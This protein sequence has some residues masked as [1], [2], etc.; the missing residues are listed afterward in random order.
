MQDL[1]TDGST[2]AGRHARD[3]D[4]IVGDNGNIIRIVGTARDDRIDNVPSSL[5]VTFNYDN[6]GPQKTGVPAA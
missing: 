1:P 6:Y 3:A 4:T 2:P 5:Y